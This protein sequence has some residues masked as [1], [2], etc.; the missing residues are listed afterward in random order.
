LEENSFVLSMIALLMLIQRSWILFWA[1]ANKQI[2]MKMMMII[3][4]LK[5]EMEL[6]TN[7]LTMKK[8]KILTNYQNQGKRKAF[9]DNVIYILW[10][11]YCNIK[12]LFYK[13]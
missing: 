8:K 2:S 6:M 10:M 11:I 1:L 12:Y 9:F 4:I 5:I 13:C 7:Q 3:S